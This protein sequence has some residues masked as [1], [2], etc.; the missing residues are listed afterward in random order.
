M[1]GVR[2]AAIL[3]TA[4]STGRPSQTVR[5]GEWQVHGRKPT[6]FAKAEEVR[7]LNTEGVNPTHIAKKVSIGR[8]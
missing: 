3:I 4:L 5:G 1:A 6:A 7:K 8:A 2:L